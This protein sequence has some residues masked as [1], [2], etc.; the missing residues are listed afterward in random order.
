MVFYGLWKVNNCV[1]SHD[2]FPPLFPSRAK[3][4]D[5]NHACE[6]RGTPAAEPVLPLSPG[7]WMAAAAGSSPRKLLAEF[8]ESALAL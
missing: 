8:A 5:P 6:H 2:D 3:P 1:R 7:G 4:W